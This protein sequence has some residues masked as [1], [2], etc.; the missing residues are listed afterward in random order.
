MITLSISSI[1]ASIHALTA[2]AAFTCQQRQEIPTVLTPDRNNALAPLI[3]DSATSIAAQLHLTAAIDGDII[4]IDCD[5]RC[6]Q[7]ASA[8]A[9]V[10]RCQVL[11]QIYAISNPQGAVAWQQSASNALRSLTSIADDIPPASHSATS[12]TITPTFY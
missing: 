10:V 6:Q 12:A 9:E 5:T 2:L 1:A 11:A 3:A 4:T 7:M 8:M